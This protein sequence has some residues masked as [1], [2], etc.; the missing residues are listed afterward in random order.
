VADAVGGDLDQDMA[1]GNVGDV[2]LD[3]LERGAGALI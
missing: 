2:T 1:A 3:E